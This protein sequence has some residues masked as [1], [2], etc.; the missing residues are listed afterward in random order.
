M[1]WRQGQ[2][3]LS[4][5]CWFLLDFVLHKL[6]VVEHDGLSITV[7]AGNASSIMND[8]IV[9]SIGSQDEMII[10]EGQAYYKC[11]G[12]HRFVATTCVHMFRNDRSTATE[13]TLCYAAQRYASFETN[14][15]L[16][17]SLSI[18]SPFPHFTLDAPQK[19]HPLAIPIIELYR[20]SSSAPFTKLAKSF[21]THSI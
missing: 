3:L 20:K 13:S 11:C 7:W 10:S 9:R 19:C 12:R 5:S 16:K 17:C 15:Q 6:L 1:A 21:L 14:A 2:L 8:S 4:A 18:R